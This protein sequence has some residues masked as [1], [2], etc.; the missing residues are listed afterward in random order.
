MGKAHPLTGERKVD[1]KKRLDRAWEAANA[2]PNHKEKL[3][4]VRYK[5]TIEQGKFL[6]NQRYNSELRKIKYGL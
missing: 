1:I 6:E 5:T 3:A 2:D 4:Q